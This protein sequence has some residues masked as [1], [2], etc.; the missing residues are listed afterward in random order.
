MKSNCVSGF[1]STRANSHTSTSIIVID[2][3]FLTH[4]SHSCSVRKGDVLFHVVI[5]VVCDVT[6]V[7]FAGAVVVICIGVILHV[8][9][10]WLV[11]F[12]WNLAFH[13]LCATDTHI[14]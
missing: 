14:I 3:I 4:V 13:V 12:T 6:I 5:Q 10:S 2:S 8:T 9:Q 11:Y 7:P 1:T